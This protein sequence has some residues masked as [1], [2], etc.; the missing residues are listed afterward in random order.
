MFFPLD[1][2]GMQIRLFA[3]LSISTFGF[4]TLVPKKDLCIMID[5]AL[6]TEHSLPFTFICFPLI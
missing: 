5:L 4:S 2:S 1:P 3:D 6:S